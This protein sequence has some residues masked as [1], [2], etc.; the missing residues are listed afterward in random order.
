MM[1]FLLNKQVQL[2]I[3]VPP[4]ATPHPV[5]VLPENVIGFPLLKSSHVFPS[6]TAGNL[7]APSLVKKKKVTIVTSSWL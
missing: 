4:I 5:I 2:D 3:V 1:L 7:Q 6:R